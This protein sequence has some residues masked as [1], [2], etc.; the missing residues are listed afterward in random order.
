M[1]VLSLDWQ[2][3]DTHVLVRIPEAEDPQL[4]LQLF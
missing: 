2:G 1:D 4:M 3:Q